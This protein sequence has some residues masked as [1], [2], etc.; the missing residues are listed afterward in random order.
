MLGIDQRLC[1]VAL[2][3]A[4]RR[5]HL[6]RFIIHRIALDLL[7]VT[8]YLRFALLEKFIQPLDLDLEA[9]FALLLTFDLDLRMCISL[10][11]FFH[12]AL[13]FLLQLITLVFEFIERAA[14]FFGD[15]RREFHAI[16]R[17]V[18]AAQQIQFIA[19][20][21]NITE[22]G[23]DLFLHG[24]HKGGNRAVIRSI[25]IRERNEEDVFMAGAFDLART[26]HALGVG[27]QDNLQQDL[28]MDGC[29][30]GHIVFVAFIEDRQIDVLVHQSVDGVFQSPGT[31]WSWSE[32]GSITI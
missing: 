9:S 29:R 18:R 11:M 17:K 12:H 14:P 22:D 15:I 32:M 8:A 3:D 6:D 20:R 19:Y 28:G 24:R 13:E 21:E 1:V 2:N 7:A 31:S 16:E 5:R 30:T 23:R 10:R 27:Q 25:P 26:D 4:V